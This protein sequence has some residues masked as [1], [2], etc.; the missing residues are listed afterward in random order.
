[1]GAFG[2]TIAAVGNFSIMYGEALLKDI[3]PV[4]AARHPLVDGKRIQTNHPVW[5]YGHLAIY[6]SRM[7]DLLGT[8]AG[9]FAKPAGWDDLFKNGTECKD[10]AAGTIYP[11]LEKV[12]RF[13]IDSYKAVQGALVEVDDAVLMKPNPGEGRMKELLPT[14]GGVVTFLLTGHP[15][16]HLGQ[17]STWRRVMGLGS[18]M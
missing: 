9:Q 1:M 8:P 4:T 17:V 12:S 15:M 14:V 13:Y 18:A 10:D 6:S 16:S 2:K 3:T 5:V 11:S 7:L